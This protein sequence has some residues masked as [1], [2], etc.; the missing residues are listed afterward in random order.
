MNNP[1]D[2]ELDALVVWLEE[3]P[4]CHDGPHETSAR[5]KSCEKTVADA[6]TALRAQLAEAKAD[7]EKLGRELNLA[8][9]GNPDF[10]WQ[11]HKEALAEMKAELARR[12]DMHECAMAERDDATLY[13]E[14]QKARA[15]R[16]E[17]EVRSLKAAIFGSENYAH[18][19]KC[20]NFVEMAQ[21]LHAAQKGGLDRADRAEAE[22]AAQIEADARICEA[23]R[24][25]WDRGYNTSSTGF[26]VCRSLANVR[27][28]IRNQPHDRTD[29]DRMLAEARE[30]ALRDAADEMEDERAKQAILALIEKP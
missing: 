16:A 5:C 29:L 6:I 23:E 28:V 22:R 2:E 8:R 30:K 7:K 15:D 14:E 26:C 10:S 27:D 13:S 4:C 17:A 12:V 3:L 9:Y 1:T 25:L 18:D 20:G 19:L 11:V 21:A 24:K